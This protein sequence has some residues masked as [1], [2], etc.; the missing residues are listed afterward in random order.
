MKIGVLIPT[1]GDRHLFL[2]HSKKLLEKQT[3]KPDEILIVDFEPT[4]DKID[5]TKRYRLGSQTLF[6]EKKC[7]LV[8]FWEDDDWY[9][10]NYIEKIFNTWK[11]NKPSVIGFGKTIYYHLFTKN[12]LIIKHPFRASACCTAV[13]KD[14]LNINYPDDSYPYLD[15][16]V[17]KQLPN[18]VVINEDK[19]YHI[20]LKHG[21][22]KTGGGG[23]PTNWPKYEK[24]DNDNSFINS[25]IDE[26]S[27]KFYESLRQTK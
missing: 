26:E 11:I 17:W 5:I 13:T 7:D 22:G 6:T 14:I 4:D 12:Y 10:P 2:N 15:V 3:L 23:H 24:S 9:S 16:E 19:F 20:G 21:I 8:L 27:F 18:K 25:I 1:R